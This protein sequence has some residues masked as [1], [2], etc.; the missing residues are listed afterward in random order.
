MTYHQVAQPAFEREYETGQDYRVTLDT[1]Q[2]IMP[3]IKPSLEVAIRTV[4]I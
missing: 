4:A 3:N 2:H 1:F